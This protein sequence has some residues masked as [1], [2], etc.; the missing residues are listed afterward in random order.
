MTSAQ[1]GRVQ[2]AITEANRKI[3]EVELAL[4]QRIRKELAETHAA[5]LNSLSEGSVLRLPTRLR[6]SVLRFAGQGHRSSACSS[7]RSAGSSSRRGRRRDRAARR[8]PAAR[9]ARSSRATS[10]SCALVR[11]PSSSLPPT[12][13][14]SAAASM[15]YSNTSAPML[16]PARRAAPS[17]PSACAPRQADHR[18]GPA[19]SFSRRDCPKVE[20]IAGEKPPCGHLPSGRSTR[21]ERE[22]SFCCERQA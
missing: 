7:R 16:I 4:P 6:R 8:Q 5:K 1:I 21:Q 3:Q 11:R 9:A 12:T 10:P 2:A 13:S 17:T 19:R 15:A 22:A 14:R 18:Q 20:T